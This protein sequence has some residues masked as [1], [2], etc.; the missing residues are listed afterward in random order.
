[1]PEEREP[2]DS[3]VFYETHFKTLIKL[4]KQNQE[5]FSRGMIALAEY[6]FY[7]KETDLSDE[8][9]LDMFMDM[10]K[11]NLDA[12]YRKYINGKK[13]GAPKGNKNAV[14]D[15]TTKNN[16]EQP[17]VNVN[18]NVSVTD[19]VNV[20]VKAIIEYLNI[21]TGKNYKHSRPNTIKHISARLN[22]GFTIDDFYKVIDYKVTEWK[23]TDYEQYLRPDTLFGN[24]FEGYL[25]S[26]KTVKQND[27]PYPTLN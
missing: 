9:L 6:G 20:S 7:G 2:R 16:Q 14:K 3:F 19:N 10:A 21:K 18:G 11:P 24:K 17:N 13:G 25:N 27:N 1:M 8:P 23:G 4:K 12:N 15:K 26:V 5:L 22:E